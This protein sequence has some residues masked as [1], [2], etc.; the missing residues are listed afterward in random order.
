MAITLKDA[1][2]RLNV[3][4]LTD[5]HSYI[6]NRIATLEITA[7]MADVVR[8]QRQNPVMDA[9]PPCRTEWNA[10]RHAMFDLE[11]EQKA[12]ARANANGPAH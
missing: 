8:D 9:M 11:Q 6:A 3:A 2:D 7:T 5:L 12:A 10:H 4:Q 1:V